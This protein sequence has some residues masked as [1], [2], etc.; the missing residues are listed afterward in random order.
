MSRAGARESQSTANGSGGASAW[1]VRCHQADAPA[2]GDL[3]RQPRVDVCEQAG[4]LWLRGDSLSA[5][6]EQ[7][8]RS[9]PG[10]V[11]YQVLADGQIVVAGTRVPRGHLPKGPWLPLQDWITA[12]IPPAALA[13]QVSAC[14]SPKLV[15]STRVENA[16][17]LL[18]TF[19]HWAAYA[20]KAPE[21][22]LNCLRFALAKNG[23]T[24]ICATNPMGRELFND[25]KRPTE[26]SEDVSSEGKH[27]LMDLP[28]RGNPL[29]PIPGRRCVDYDG[30]VVPVGYFWSPAIDAAMLRQLMGLASGDLALWRLDGRWE[31]IAA[32][33]F[34]AATRS[35]V[36]ASIREMAAKRPV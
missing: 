19:A 5:A 30:I 32:D 35:A 28:R 20:T 25:G 9:L 22:R 26:V 33:D 1:A 12:E 2:L 23:R 6:L 14:A 21:V 15:R 11:R 13:G 8:L 24:L 29:P 4:E 3:R 27:W 31:R 34:V 10:A 17:A 36:R 16:N 18:T 7:Q